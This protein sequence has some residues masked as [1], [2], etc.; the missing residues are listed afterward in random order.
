MVPVLVQASSVEA[1]KAYIDPVR[2]ILHM[3]SVRS[4]APPNSGPHLVVEAL[5]ALLA[6]NR[7]REP[8]RL[9]P[10]DLCDVP[11]RHFDESEGL[12]TAWT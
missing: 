5:S 9:K 3:P 4:A 2:A 6:V 10:R 7:L 11:A 1:N 12:L 8:R